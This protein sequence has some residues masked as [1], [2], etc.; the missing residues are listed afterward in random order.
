[1]TGFVNRGN[2]NYTGNKE[3][4]MNI[5]HKG[6]IL[7]LFLIAFNS[8]NPTSKKLTFEELKVEKCLWVKELT[9]NMV[10]FKSNLCK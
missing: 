4:K 6:L 10:G 7:T 5:L 3:I 2:I 1:L 9:K 8:Y